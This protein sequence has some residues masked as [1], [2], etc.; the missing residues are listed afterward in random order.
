MRTITQRETGKDSIGQVH[1]RQVS[2]RHLA[3][4]EDAVSAFPQPSTTAQI[5]SDSDRSQ[6][7]LPGSDQGAQGRGAVAGGMRHVTVRSF[8]LTIAWIA[9]IL[10]WSPH[11]CRLSCSRAVGAIRQSVALAASPQ[12]CRVVIEPAHARA[13]P[14]VPQPTPS[15]ASRAP[16]VPVHV[17]LPFHAGVGAAGAAGAGGGQRCTAV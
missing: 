1:D 2:R 8:H 14:A 11:Q 15:P 4:G 12:V 6:K 17:L 7:A 10:R 9:L 16:H 13:L 5:I 3:T